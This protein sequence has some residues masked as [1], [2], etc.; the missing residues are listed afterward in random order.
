MS[1][2]PRWMPE[3]RDPG[4]RTCSGRGF[5][6]LRH[7]DGPARRLGEEVDRQIEEVQATIEQA[8]R[9]LDRSHQLLG[10]KSASRVPSSTGPASEDEA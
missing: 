8:D 2:Q 9:V 3:R 7:L 6:D 1:V 5:R 10:D 4:R